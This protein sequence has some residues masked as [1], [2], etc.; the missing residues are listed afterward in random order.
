MV[1]QISPC[2][3]NELR[4]VASQ[5]AQALDDIVAEAVR[6]Y[7]DAAA[8]TEVTPEDITATQEALLGELDDQ[9]EWDHEKESASDEA[10]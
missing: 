1:I 4:R 8:I 7:L 5:R 3:E 9:P 10:R 6:Q 2:L